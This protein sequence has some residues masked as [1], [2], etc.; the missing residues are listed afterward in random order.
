MEICD[1]ESAADNEDVLC[2]RNASTKCVLYE[3]GKCILELSAY[4][5]ENIQTYWDGIGGCDGTRHHEGL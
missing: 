1:G 3:H 4:D 2:R 5:G